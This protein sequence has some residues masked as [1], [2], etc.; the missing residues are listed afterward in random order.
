MYNFSARW[1]SKHKVF[2]RDLPGTSMTQNVGR[3][4]TKTLCRWPFSVVLD[5]EC[6]GY[7]G[8]GSG[9]PRLWVG[10]SRIWK[11]FMQE[12]FGLIFLTLASTAKEGKF[13]RAS[14]LC[15]FPA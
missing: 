4:Q 3:P 11:N 6:S 9:C 1:Y 5:R 7:L 2:G 13:I 15:L 10:T 12:N 14:H 8:F